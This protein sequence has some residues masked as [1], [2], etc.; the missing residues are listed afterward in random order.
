MRDSMIVGY[1][2]NLFVFGVF[3]N[4]HEYARNFVFFLGEVGKDPPLKN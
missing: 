1:Y 3:D 2:L 4:C